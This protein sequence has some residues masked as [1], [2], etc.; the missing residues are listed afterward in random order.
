MADFLLW[1]IVPEFLYGP[2]GTHVDNHR[3]SQKGQHHGFRERMS[4]L[5]RHLHLPIAFQL[6]GRL[7]QGPVAAVV[8]GNFLW[9]DRRRQQPDGLVR[10][11]DQ[12]R[13]EQTP[14]VRL[15]QHLDNS[16][17]A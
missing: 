2:E 3:K 11:S 14:G 1:L 10:L 9:S 5:S 15:G 17:D 7:P 8:R 16:V 6:H 13:A 12:L 4:H